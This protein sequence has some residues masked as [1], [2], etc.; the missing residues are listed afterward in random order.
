MEENETEKKR[1]VRQETRLRNWKKGAKKSKTKKLMNMKD[2]TAQ[3]D[4]FNTG[5][6]SPK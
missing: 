6:T 1:K 3:A 5:K 4:F 2:D